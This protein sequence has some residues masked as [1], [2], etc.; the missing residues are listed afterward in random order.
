M[1]ARITVSHP[2]RRISVSISSSTDSSVLVIWLNT[3][4]TLDTELEEATG[5]TT[6]ATLCAGPIDLR[7]L[8]VEIA[9]LIEFLGYYTVSEVS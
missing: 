5:G 2:R 9:G 1:P 3:G 8:D 6:C 7:Q 4:P